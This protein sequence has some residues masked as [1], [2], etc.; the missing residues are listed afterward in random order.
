MEDKTILEEL[1]ERGADPRRRKTE[2]AYR[3]LAAGRWSDAEELLCELLDDEPY[4]PDA[5]TG[6]SLAE[7]EKSVRA[8]LERAGGRAYRALPQPKTAE[9]ESRLPALLRSGWLCAFCAA[10]FTAFTCALLMAVPL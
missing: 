5:L 2:E 7:R 6:L 3:L 1:I 10:A 4:N 9:R 8:R